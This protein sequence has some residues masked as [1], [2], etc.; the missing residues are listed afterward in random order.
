[1]KDKE[2]SRRSCFSDNIFMET[3]KEIEEEILNGKDKDVFAALA[4]QKKPLVLYGAGGNCEQAMFLCSVFETVVDGVCDSRLTGIYK[5]KHQSWNILSPEEL[6]EK[7]KD[8]YVM[9]TSWRYEKEISDMLLEKGYP[10]QNI[11]FHRYPTMELEEF[12]EKYLAGYRWA[13]NFFEDEGSKARIINRMRRYLLGLPC[14]ADSLYKDGY[15]GYPKI[16]LDEEVYVD[17]GAYTGDTAEEFIEK[18]RKSGKKWKNIYSFEPDKE[19]CKITEENLKKYEHISLVRA[20]LW[21]KS[22]TLSFLRDE[23]TAGLASRLVEKED[24]NTV[25]VPVVSLDEF[26]SEMPESDWP[27]LIKMD[28]EGAEGKALLGAKKILQNKKPKLMICAYHKPEDI[29]ELP[30]IVS[31][32]NPEYHLELWQIGESFWEV[33]LYA[34]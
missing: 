19:I 9:I 25:F 3:Y 24:E 23:G 15:F 7:Y 10:E 34:L 30:R 16:A 5:Y 21:E 12:R 33:C 11:F 26:F 13:Y 2:T 20:G 1:M 32:L 27:T 31:E 28:L 29:Y 6:L 8:A 18:I 17:G 4:K 14:P 22:T